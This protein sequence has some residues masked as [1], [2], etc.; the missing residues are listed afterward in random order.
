MRIYVNYEYE[1]KLFSMEDI[2]S[3]LRFYTYNCGGESTM[4]TNKNQFSNKQKPLIQGEQHWPSGMHQIN[5]L[6]RDEAMKLG[7]NRYDDA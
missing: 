2:S 4:T 1:Y 6:V 7:C 5:V 3:K